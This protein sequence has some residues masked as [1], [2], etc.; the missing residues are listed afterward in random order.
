MREFFDSS[1][2][3]MDLTST[4][5]E[6]V[7]NELIDALDRNGNLYNREEYKKAILLKESQAST[8]ISDGIA[9]PHA[10]TS[11]VKTPAVVFGRSV[12][13]INFDSLDGKDSHLFFMIA[14][15]EN[16]DDTHLKMLAFLSRK[17]LDVSFRQTL[18]QAKTSEEVLSF[19]QTMVSYEGA[20]NVSNANGKKIIAVTA[21]P[22]GIAH[23]F[24]AADKLIQTALE[25]GYE[26]KVETNGATGVENRLTEKDI[27]EADGII[28]AVGKTVE[29]NRF[30]GKKVVQVP[31]TDAIKKPKALIEQ[32][33]S[34][35]APVY[36]SS[37]SGTD[38][39]GHKNQRVGI[40]R[41]LMNGVSEMLPFV[42]SGGI[43]IAICFLFGHKSFD[44]TDP[45]YNAFAA[46][47]F[48]I[49]AK[50]A[51]ALMVP[52]LAAFIGR[53]IADRPGFVAGMV[54]GSIAAT[55]GSG[56]LGGIIAGF[57]AGYLALAIKKL[58][59]NTPKWLDSVKA[60][61][62]FPLLT[63]FATGAIML[64]VINQPLADLNL[65]LTHWLQQLGGTNSIILGLLL[66]AMMAIDMGGP[67]NKAAYVFATGLLANHLY[68]PMAAV[69]AGGMVPPLGVAL[70]T[71]LF[72][73]RF[74][75]DEREAGKTALVLGSF[76]IT[77]GAIPF[78]AADPS[79]VIPSLVIGSA[80]A[81]A[82]S[83][84][85][86]LGLTTSHGGVIVFGFIQGGWLKY[87]FAIAMGSIITALSLG[88]LK[89]RV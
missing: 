85:F 58:L 25:L 24:M 7:I 80:V 74:T 77:E 16:M 34:V 1:L 59:S 14:A 55:G 56:F 78:A 52:I 89:K 26:I 11:A 30:H 64:T 10:K 73:N 32:S 84:A 46:M 87:V 66:G 49:G 21:C 50:H 31:V 22:T 36:V 13:G 82:L 15:D 71:V 42:I 6:S 53:S 63:V 27:E 33:L 41:H 47:V 51:F 72:K 67:I 12:Q 18:L 60:V 57:L 88:I 17:L 29:M 65:F 86:H 8:G 83:M 5:K 4:D 44:K 54:G 43:L 19:L 40:Y 35:R 70:A 79:R 62:I 39:S 23:T 38:H 81:G 61:L 45:S 9:I 3:L 75:K 76:F 28:V 48:E 69:M 2:V 20:L 68:E 37:Q